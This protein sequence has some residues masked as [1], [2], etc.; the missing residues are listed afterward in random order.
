[1][2]LPVADDVGDHAGAGA[3][4]AAQPEAVLLLNHLG[5]EQ[6]IP[7]EHQGTAVVVRL[8]NLRPRQEYSFS[9]TTRLGGPM[10]AAMPWSGATFV[11]LPGPPPAPV[12]NAHGG[13]EVSLTIHRNAAV[14]QYLVGGVDIQ[15]ADN[16]YMRGAS[17][18]TRRGVVPDPS[19][20]QATM[21]VV[22]D[23]V[24]G[25]RKYYFRTRSRYQTALGL[26]LSPW[27]D[28]TA[29]RGPLEMRDAVKWAT[30]VAG[31]VAVRMVCA[32]AA[33]A[34]DVCESVRDVGKHVVGT[35]SL[36]C[37]LGVSHAHSESIGTLKS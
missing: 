2:A 6:E 10:A 12:I 17:V 35:R 5:L 33:I 29:G 23:D 20:H 15:Y 8:I 11:T 22:V 32:P 36:A 4:G 26:C 13:S 21:E 30:Y 3:A 37:A 9:S 7:R 25:H 19:P 24:V 34:W 14:G 16:P 1:M 27:S 31:K 28:I 18:R